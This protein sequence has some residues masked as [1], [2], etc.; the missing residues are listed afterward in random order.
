MKISN[1]LCNHTNQ[2]WQLFGIISTL[3]KD[4]DPGSGSEIPDFQD[5]DLDPDP[6]PKI[7]ISEPEHWFFPTNT[8]FLF[9]QIK[10]FKFLM[11]TTQN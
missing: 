10:R 3:Q 6:D 4:P 5:E 11:K 2:N 7:L 9:M 8:N 1:H